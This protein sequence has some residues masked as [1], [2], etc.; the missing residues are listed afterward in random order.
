MREEKK[1]KCSLW[2]Q[3]HNEG[4][5]MG[6]WLWT[7]SLKT[8]QSGWTTYRALCETLAWWETERRIQKVRLTSFVKV[9]IAQTS[10]SGS[11][12]SNQQGLHFHALLPCVCVCF[13]QTAN[14][15]LWNCS[16]SGVL[17]LD[18]TTHTEFWAKKFS[19]GRFK[20]SPQ[21][22]TSLWLQLQSGQITSHGWERAL[23]HLF[24]RCGEGWDWKCVCTEG[25]VNMLQSNRALTLL[26]GFENLSNL[27][28]LHH[29][30]DRSDEPHWQNWHRIFTLPVKVSFLSYCAAFQ[31]H[32]QFSWVTLSTVMPMHQNTTSGHMSPEI[33]K[34]ETKTWDIYD[35]YQIITADVT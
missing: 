22:P 3:S 20:V 5:W 13:C 25:I 4:C 23:V 6:L 2:L 17:Y 18:F 12:Q 30:C 15:S 7:M 8:V 14:P 21:W 16:V 33:C 34:H 26:K 9:I 10:H 24:P 31:T 27:L 29:H 19:P 11:S 1:N 35:T 32:A 28:M